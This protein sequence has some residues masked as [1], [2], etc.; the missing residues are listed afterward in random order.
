MRNMLMA[1]IMWYAVSAHSQEIN[2][3][4][5]QAIL[6]NNA[7]FL[8]LSN[9]TFSNEYRDRGFRLITELEWENTGDKPIT[10]FEI[11]ILSYDPFNRPVRSGGAWLITGTNSAD[12][13]PLEPGE[14]NGD[15]LI[16]LAEEPV[17][18]SIAFVRAAR[19]SD[20]TVWKFDPNEVEEKVKAALPKAEVVD[21]ET[22]GRDE[23]D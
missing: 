13:T 3:P 22:T 1:S 11:V 20:G 5:K 23:T 15:G 2:F 4:D 7:P 19:M 8:E 14:R 9:F 6:L 10:A 16:G 21:L 12:W 18:T 17:F